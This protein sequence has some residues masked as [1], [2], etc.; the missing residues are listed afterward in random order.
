M[1]FHLFNPRN[2]IT[3]Y[4]FDLELL[5]YLVMII[6]LIS[7]YK[8]EEYTEIQ[9]LPAEITRYPYIWIKKTV[10]PINCLWKYWNGERF[11]H[12]NYINHNQQM[13]KNLLE[14]VGSFFCLQLQLYVC[15]KKIYVRFKILYPVSGWW[16]SFSVIIFHSNM[17]NGNYLSKDLIEN[18]VVDF[19]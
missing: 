19:G 12:V 7:K 16:F 14:K 13:V 4:Y 3:Q 11:F 1:A 6:L 17:V 10:P 18:L 8:Y 15:E 5:G 9:K 2:L